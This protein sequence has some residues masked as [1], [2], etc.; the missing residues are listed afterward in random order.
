[1]QPQK[2]ESSLAKAEYSLL[3]GNEYSACV[4]QL[5]LKITGEKG[6]QEDGWVELEKGRRHN[7]ES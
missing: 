6:A 5:F 4:F 2:R 1:M 3:L 7:V